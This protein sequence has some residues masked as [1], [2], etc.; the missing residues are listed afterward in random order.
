MLLY[1][2]LGSNDIGRSRIFYDAAL[3]PLGLYCDFSGDDELGY[4]AKNRAEG[5]REC[6]LWIDRPYLKL[7]ATWGNGTMIALNAA[8][9]KAVDEFYEAGLAH[10]GID[11][12]A[13]GL[14]PYHATF[15]A[16]Y[17]RDPDG[18]KLSA[19]CERPNE[20]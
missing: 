7:P 1:V 15:Y 4:G 9:R 6:I 5:Q 14:R 8:T 20:G 10:G 13:P 17:L 19:V 3:A 12:G 16:A 11:E 2:T 18:N